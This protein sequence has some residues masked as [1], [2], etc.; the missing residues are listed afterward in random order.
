M[1]GLLLRLPVILFPV[2]ELGALASVAFVHSYPSTVVAFLLT[3]IGLGDVYSLMIAFLV[4]TDDP[5]LSFGLQWKLGSMPAHSWSRRF[6]RLR[7]R[8]AATAHHSH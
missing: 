2:V 1:R 4:R 7:G 6:P 3:S 8:R 5:N